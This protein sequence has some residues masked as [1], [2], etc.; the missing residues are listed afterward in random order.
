MA[1]ELHLH[2]RLAHITQSVTGIQTPLNKSETNSMHEI[3][4]DQNN[5]LLFYYYEFCNAT[6]ASDGS[7]SEMCSEMLHDCDDFYY[8][9]QHVETIESTLIDF[10]R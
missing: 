5:L 10:T 6:V 9:T 8:K 2:K 4:R 1:L 3:K 7:V